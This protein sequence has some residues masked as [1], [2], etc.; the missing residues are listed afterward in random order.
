[1]ISVV[2]AT[3]NGERYIKQQIESIIPQITDKDEILICDDNSTDSTIKVVDDI[4]KKTNTQYSIYVNEKN[5]GV[6][7]T[8][9]KLAKNAKGDIVVFC[10]Q[11][12]YWLP[13][14]T[15]LFIEA[16]KKY[17]YDLAFSNAYITDSNLQP[18]G[19]TLWDNIQLDYDKLGI[20]ERYT[21]L[22]SFSLSEVLV[23]HNIVTGMSMAVKRSF[24]EKNVPF[25]EHM[26]H[27]RWLALNACT[28][29]VTV[30]IN[31][32]LAKY[33]Q[34]QQNV[35][36]ARKGKYFKKMKHS[37]RI[38]KELLVKEKKLI[39][40][41]SV[42]YSNSKNAV[43]F[44]SLNEYRE[45]IEKRY[46]YMNDKRQICTLHKLYK[47]G[48]YKKYYGHAKLFYIRDLILL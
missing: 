37:F 36:G 11:D 47:D 21:L 27:D 7:K 31:R 41:I 22:D 42:L 43:C 45:F 33:R 9:E 40:S 13:E 44:D 2:I 26:L 25:P 39:D 32:P 8:F 16:F 17:N 10:D 18:T 34:H 35:V 38:R 1:M 3:Y 24:L 12:D 20:Y 19:R 29:G 23:R 4:L 5:L 14:K 28:N 48:L 30:A 46:C 6:V 15:S